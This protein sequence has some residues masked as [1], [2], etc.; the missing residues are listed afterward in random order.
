MSDSYLLDT[1]PESKT[2]FVSGKGSY[3]FDVEGKEYLDF[4][5][6][7]AVTAL[8]HANDEIAQTISAQSAKLVHVS[9]YFENEYTQVVAQKLNEKIA[10]QSGESGKVFFANSGAEANECAIKIAK[11]FGARSKYKFLTAL[12]SFHGRTLA[13]LAATGQNEKHKNF[14]PLPDYFNYFEFGNIE[15]LKSQID[16]ETVAVMIEVIQGENGVRTTSQEFFDDLKTVVKENNLL[17]IVDEI[18]TGMCRTGKWFG[19]Q[20][21]GLEPD[22]VTMAK[23]LGNGFPVGGCWAKENVAQCMQKGDHGST[24]G[25]QPLALATA[26]AVIDIMTRDQ[27]YK[28]AEKS[29]DYLVDQLDST[30]LFSQVRGKGLLVGADLDRNKVSINAHELVSKCFEN[31][32]VINATSENTI[33]L[34]PALIISGEEINIGVSKIVESARG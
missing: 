14:L 11:R 27:L 7:I 18:Q 26:N 30:G 3:L 28:N 20:H 31:G 4:L 33:R 12:G 6:G 24:F 19:F 23:S 15:S 22:I 16:S 1:Y 9:N 5:G 10:G 8:G 29:G 32:L 34:A 21:Y 2:T 13:T 25:G 17:L